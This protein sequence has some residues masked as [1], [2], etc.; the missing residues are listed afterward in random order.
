M[1][2][3]VKMDIRKTFDSLNHCFLLIVLK[4]FGFG[5]NLLIRLKSF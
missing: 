5:T 1:V 4:K 2:V 3:L